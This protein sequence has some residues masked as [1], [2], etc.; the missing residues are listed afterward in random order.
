[1]NAETKLG[2]EAVQAAISMV[3]CDL[4]DIRTWSETTLKE[5]PRLETVMLARIAV[6]DRAM[7]YASE[8]YLARF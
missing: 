1:M 7:R 2:D 8:L 6:V 4:R 3:L 5:D